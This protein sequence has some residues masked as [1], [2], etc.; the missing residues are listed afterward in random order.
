MEC[1]AEKMEKDESY[2]RVMLIAAG[3]AMAASCEPCLNHV[4]PNLIEV[5]V[6]ESR[7]R[8]AAGLKVQF[9]KVSDCSSRLALKWINRKSTRACS[10]KDG[11]VPYFGSRVFANLVERP[12]SY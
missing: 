10:P 1:P 11:G 12:C 2:Q 9:A 3:S 5:G 6:P 8:T 4:I 7:I